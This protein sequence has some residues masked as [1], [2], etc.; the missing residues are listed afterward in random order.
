MKTS[1]WAAVLMMAWATCVA[2]AQVHKCKDSVGKIT[3]SNMPCPAGAQGGQI[4]LRQN[5]IDSRDSYERN[6][7]Y[8]QQRQYDEA[9]RQAQQAQAE[10]EQMQR[11]LLE[12]ALRPPEPTTAAAPLQPVQ[13]HSRRKPRQPGYAPP[14]NQPTPRVITH[15]AG[16]FCHDNQGGTTAMP[17]QT[18][19]NS[20]GTTCTSMGGTL[21]CN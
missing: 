4:E 8:L 11:E 13:S 10:Q 17:P 12:R 5:V 18:F 19:T 16:G 15:C 2:Q 9:A 3:Y 1:Q 7:R 6:V 21:T 20:D 14:A